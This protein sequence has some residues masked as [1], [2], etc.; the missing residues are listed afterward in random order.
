MATTRNFTVNSTAWTLIASGRGD[1]QAVRVEGSGPFIL[2]VTVGKAAAIPDLP[3]LTGHRIDA[4]AD[5]P[6]VAR[7]HL[8]ASASAPTQ[9]TVT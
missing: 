7:Q 1:G 5:V 3:A 4:V 6:L 2:C 8:W 9:L